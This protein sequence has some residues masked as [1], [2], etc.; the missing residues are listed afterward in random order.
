VKERKIIFGLIVVALII[1]GLFWL[2][3]QTLQIDVEKL[4]SF[5]LSFGALGSVIFI[6]FSV[7]S[8][9]FSP[10]T[11]FPFWLASLAL[12]GF[13]STFFYILISNSLGSVIN[14]LIAKRFGRPLVAKFVGQKS[15]KKIDEFSEVMGLKVLFIARLFGGAATDYI[16]YAAGLT[17]MKFK[18]YLWISLFVPIP[19][20][21]LNVYLIDQALMLK[22]VYIAFLGI[23]GYI[24]AMLFPILVYKKVKKRK[25]TSGRTLLEFANQAKKRAL[26]DVSRSHNEYLYGK[27]SQ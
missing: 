8:V 7:F 5:I 23:L 12:F 26:K 15:V 17:S 22:T 27:K 9:V 4:K 3:K 14:F 13:W 25:K 6:L 18:P 20:T 11:A 21:F 1:L 16:S 10:L 19:M 24:L 2:Q